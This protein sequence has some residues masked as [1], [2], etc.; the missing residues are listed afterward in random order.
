MFLCVDMCDCECVRFPPN[1]FSPSL[2]LTHTHTHTLSLSLSLSL[3]ANFVSFAFFHTINNNRE[4]ADKEISSVAKHINEQVSSLFYIYV[5]I[6]FSSVRER[7]RQLRIF[8]VSFSMDV[9][10]VFVCSFL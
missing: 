4:K 5:C 3:F 1:C 2:S 10:D 9:N 8:F 6:F 7:E